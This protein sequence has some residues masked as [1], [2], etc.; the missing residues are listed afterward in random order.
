MTERAPLA[1]LRDM[2]DAI[3]KARRFVAG[4]DLEA[5]LEDEKTIFAV[6]RALEIIGEAAKK[7][8]EELKRQ[9]DHIPWRA[10]TGMR[11]K[12]VHD[13]MGINVRRVFE[14]VQQDLPLL[15]EHIE[16]MISILEERME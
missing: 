5:F 6:A 16:V 10:M 3:E 15:Q 1:Y 13:Y 2:R 14:T 9:F 11:D 4:M 7:V 12:L 8:P